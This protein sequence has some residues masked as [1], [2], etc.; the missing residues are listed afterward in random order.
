MKRRGHKYTNIIIFIIILFSALLVILLISDKKDNERQA[1]ILEQKYEEEKDKSKDKYSFNILQ[2]PAPY[3]DEFI[4]A[5]SVLESKAEGEILL[6]PDMMS[7]SDSTYYASQNRSLLDKSL[8]IKT[9]KA[10]IIVLQFI[11]Y[12]EMGYT[13]MEVES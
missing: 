3:E 2:N 8:S 6:T 1:S 4:S 12:T 7:V 10:D 9:N 13:Q 11:A 5:Y